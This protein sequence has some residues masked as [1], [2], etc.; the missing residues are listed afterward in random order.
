MASQRCCLS[1]VNVSALISGTLLWFRFAQHSKAQH[2]SM[3]HL[4]RV[5]G[6]LDVA[7]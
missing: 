2:S 5:P 3:Q 4:A 6:N 1:L 7:S